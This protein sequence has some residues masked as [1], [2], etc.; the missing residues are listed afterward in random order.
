MNKIEFKESKIL[1][2]GKV[3]GDYNKYDQDLIDTFK[4]AKLTVYTNDESKQEYAIRNK[5]GNK[6]IV[7]CK[8]DIWKMYDNFDGPITDKALI[9]AE[10]IAK[11]KIM[12][13]YTRD[14]FLDNSLKSFRIYA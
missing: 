5:S 9:E 14:I 8:N 1:F 4:E 3:S 11:G 12:Y 10:L 7:F 2:N 6:V 13:D